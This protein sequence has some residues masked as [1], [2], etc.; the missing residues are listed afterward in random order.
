MAPDWEA[1]STSPQCRVHILVLVEGGQR[2]D[3]S[4][5]CH[6]GVGQQPARGLDPVEY[7][8]PDVHQNHVGMCRPRLGDGLL[9]V[10]GLGDDPE[11]RLGGDGG[12]DPGPYQV[13]VV[14]HENGDHRFSRRS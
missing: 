3:T 7:G 6:G 11:V 2:Q 10:G 14:G 1:G 13:L 8:H 5:G 9:P 12:D 4:R